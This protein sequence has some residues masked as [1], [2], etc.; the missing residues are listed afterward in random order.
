MFCRLILALKNKHY[1]LSI[2]PKAKLIV[3]LASVTTSWEDTLTFAQQELWFSDWQLLLLS[4]RKQNA[5]LTDWRQKSQFIWSA[6][7]Q[8]AFVAIKLCCVFCLVFSMQPDWLSF[9]SLRWMRVILEQMSHYF[10]QKR[11]V[12]RECCS[13]DCAS[14]DLGLFG[15][16]KST[17]PS[18]CP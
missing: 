6:S 18:Y 17:I 9:S 11:E 2:N 8:R 7:H 3:L 14:I 13:A 15:A 1:S 16:S 12:H 10:R 5:P 4:D